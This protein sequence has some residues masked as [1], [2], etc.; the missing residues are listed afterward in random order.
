MEHSGVLFASEGSVG[1]E[2]FPLYC[3]IPAFRKVSPRS[4]IFFRSPLDS[5]ILRS[6]SFSNAA[7]QEQ[8][9]LWISP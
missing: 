7:S 2:T 6:S 5:E 8:N 1:R 4:W 9:L 3:G